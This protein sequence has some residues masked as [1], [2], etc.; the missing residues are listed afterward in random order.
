MCTVYVLT[1]SDS[2][3]SSD[4]AE[5]LNSI[6]VTDS[7]V[8]EKVCSSQFEFSCDGGLMVEEY[9]QVARWT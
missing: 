8:A 1:D 7:D 5:W 2:D 6:G 9:V 3:G 4:L